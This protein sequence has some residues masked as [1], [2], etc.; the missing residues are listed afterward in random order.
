MKTDP[1]LRRPLLAA[2]ALGLLAAWAALPA[3]HAAT[4]TGSGQAATEAR[5]AS[6][7]SAIAMRGSI[8]VV[9]RQGAREAVEVSTDDNLLPLLQTVVEGS[10]EQRTLRIQWKSGESVRTRARTLVTVDV[11]KLSSVSLAGSG[12]LTVEA[13]KTP[14]LALAISG[15][16][17]VRLQQLDAE[18]LKL[19]IAG[20]GD[21]RA[22]GT[23]G[24]L[25]V[26][27][28]GSGDVQASELQ[29]ADV[30]VSIAGSGDASVHASK[31]LAVSIAGSGDVEY[32]GGATLAKARVAGSGSIRQR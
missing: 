1:L 2:V 20:S 21:V 27:I 26:K 15:S 9:V 16:S 14:A 7:F 30:S 11:V 31:S 22:R 12:D 4:T 5:D 3:A 6:G 18:Q 13:L 24:T 17:D 23:A 28:A 8:D 10:G 19:S 32:R 25:E 29:A